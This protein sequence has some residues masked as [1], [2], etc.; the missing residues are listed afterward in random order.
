MST[1]RQ[2]FVLLVAVAVILCACSTTESP[3]AEPTQTLIPPTET[4]IPSPTRLPSETPVELPRP[5]DLITPTAESSTNSNNSQSSDVI[6][7]VAADL[8]GLAQRRLAQD[9]NLPTRRIQVV[10]VTSHIWTDTS[11][12]CPLPGE[13][14]AQVIVDG[15]RIVLS[16]GDQ[17][18]LFHTDF[19]RVV[20]CDA[21][22]EQLPEATP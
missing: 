15:Y 7:P 9:L 8:V 12:G 6:D 19:D 16:A 22:N 10:E 17:E 14:Y 21:K 13:N 11:L 4:P 3:T 20:A 2:S 18:Y 1:L 5:G